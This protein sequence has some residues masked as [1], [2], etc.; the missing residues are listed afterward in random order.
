M[1]LTVRP[2]ASLRGAVDL[3]SSKSYS[4]RAFLIASRGGVSRIINPSDC[5]DAKV[6]MAVA[7]Q[8]GSRIKKIKKNIWSVKA[9]V[10]GRKVSLINVGE[11][12]T[13]LRLVLPILALEKNNIRVIGRGTLKGRP[14]LF[15]VKTLRRMGVNIRG[16]GTQDSIPIVLK[17]GRL[18][19][20]AMAIDGTV[21]S[22]FIS[23]LL[24]VCPSLNENTR[25]TVTGRQFVSQT[26]VVMTEKI[27]KKAGI[28]LR[29]LGARRFFIKGNQRFKGLKNFTVPSDYGL[30]AF[31]M[32]AAVLVP[33]DLTLKGYFD[34]NLIQSDGQILSFL[35]R[36]GIKFTLTKSFIRIKGPQV[37]K[38]GVFSLKNC[39]DLVPI[40]AVMAL[41]AR[42]KTRLCDVGHARIKESDRLGE[43]KD[44][45]EKIGANVREKENELIITPASSYRKNVSFNPRH[46]HRLAMSFAILGLRLGVKVKDM[47]CVSKSYPQ[48]VADLKKIGA[49][50][51]KN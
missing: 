51:S 12:G 35:K 13:V 11:S 18:C 22:Q 43:L 49:S 6:A 42:G 14:N 34:K 44:E 36:M 20:G 24:T 50:V 21:S 23:A 29:R 45:L 1:I 47:E 16:Q 41:F 30:A 8:L 33:S 9:A 32:A 15:L 28:Q 48:F 39:P 4:I 3:P 40:M 5:D 17:G 37:F 7:G 10:Q 38:G 31:L 46:D 26:Y 25:L 2:A 27:L 19:G